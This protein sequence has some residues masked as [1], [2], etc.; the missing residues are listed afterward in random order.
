MLKH[1]FRVTAVILFCGGL[2]AACGSASGPAGTPGAEITDTPGIVSGQ[3]TVIMQMQTFVPRNL[4]IRVGTTVTWVNKDLLGN[5]VHAEDDSF[6]SE[7]LANQESFSFTFAQTGTYPYY[8]DTYGGP[9]GKGM[10]GVITVV[11]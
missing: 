7:T 2:L 6:R 8:S 11:P 9:G 1:H 4:T 10:S 5:D 3:A